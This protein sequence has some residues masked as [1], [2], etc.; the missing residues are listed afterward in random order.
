M[1]KTDLSGLLSKMKAI[2]ANWQLKCEDCGKVPDPIEYPG[3][4]EGDECPDC[5]PDADHGGC[6]RWEGFQPPYAGWDFAKPS[7]AVV[8]S[9]CGDGSVLW[10]A[11]GHLDFEISEGVGNVLAD[12]GLDDAPLGISVW[13]GKVNYI[14]YQCAEGGVDCDA[15]TVG[16]FRDPTPE[17]WDAIKSGRNPWNVRDWMLTHPVPVD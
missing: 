2:P 5:V 10:Y 4:V 3:H 7:R 14:E 12:L 9:N 13:V 15:E 1:M 11:G 16:E 6:L 8:A 17:E